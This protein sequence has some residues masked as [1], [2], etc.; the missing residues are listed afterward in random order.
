M[1][2]RPI[3]SYRLTIRRDDSR[4]Q[5]ETTLNHR[6]ALSMVLLIASINPSS[7]YSYGLFNRELKTYSYWSCMKEVNFP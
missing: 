3:R 1:N 6:I 2:I 4:I 7:R 5:H